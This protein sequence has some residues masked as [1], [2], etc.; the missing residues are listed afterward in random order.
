MM[1]A[2]GGWIPTIA[3][4][5]LVPP[6]DVDQGTHCATRPFVGPWRTS[7][8]FLW[9]P[10]LVTGRRGTFERAAQL[11][12][13]GHAALTLLHVVEPDLAAAVGER[14]RGLA[15]EYLRDW[16]A[17]QPEAHASAR[18]T[19]ESG[20]PLKSLSRRASEMPI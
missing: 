6:F 2:R 20:R 15:E 5:L 4:S 17:K 18:F 13:D 8:I 7:G 10:I 14:L 19:V 11:S 9:V 12:R 3:Q 1:S 16:L